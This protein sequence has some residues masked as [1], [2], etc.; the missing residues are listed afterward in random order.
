MIFKIVLDKFTS[1]DNFPVVVGLLSTAASGSVSGMAL[2][3]GIQTGVQMLAVLGSIAVSFFTVR[4]LI[5]KTKK[6]K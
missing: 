4:Y 2:V 6:L 3:E 1:N 5:V